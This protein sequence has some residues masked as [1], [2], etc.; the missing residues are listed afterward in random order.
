VSDSQPEYIWRTLS[1]FLVDTSGN[2]H[3][4]ELNIEKLWNPY[5]PGRGCLGLVEFRAFRM[6]RDPESAASI[7]AL[8]RAIVALL[9][10]QDIVPDLIDW[11]SQL[12]DRFALPFY[13]LEDLHQV[14]ADL[15]SAGLSLGGA[16]TNRLMDSSDRRLGQAELGNCRF[17]VDRAIEFWPLLGDAASQESGSSRLVDASTTRL[18]L[19]LRPAGGSKEGIDGWQLLVGDYRIP[20]REE[21]DQ[22]GILRVT[23]LRYRSFVPWTGL[24]P[25]IAAQVPIVFTLLSPSGDRG[26]RITLH[27]WQPQAA[28]YDGLPGNL[29]EARRRVNERFVVEELSAQQIPKSLALPA[30]ALSDYCVDFRRI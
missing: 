24:H 26:L 20:L 30:E 7:A 6:T 12:H 22:R 27:E 9:C 23:G 21:H 5:L 1:P 19:S 4:S 16:I 10:R 13:L 11:G 29:E 8:L 25:G 17:E 14:F 28:P 15:E 3:R 18:Q 2:A